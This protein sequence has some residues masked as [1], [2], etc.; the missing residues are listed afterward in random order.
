MH[1]KAQLKQPPVFYLAFTTAMFERFG[2]YVLTYLLVLYTKS[3]YGLSDGQAFILFGVV[4]GL[5]YLTPAIGGYLADNVLG[6]RRCILLGLFLE[7][8]GLIC[9]GLSYKI[10]FWLGLG[11]IIVGE[12]LFKTAP[13]NLMAR[14]YTEQDPRIDTGFT[15]YY[16]GMNLGGILSA[17]SCAFIQQYFGWQAAFAVAG[18]ACYL[19][20]LSYF[21]TRHSARDIDSEPGMKKLSLKTWINVTVGIV[22]AVICCTFLAHHSK[23]SDIFFFF[24]TLLILFYFLYEI[25]NSSPEDK[26]KIIACLLLIFIGMAFQVLFFQA[27]TSIILFINRNV[28][29]QLF[30]LTIPSVSFLALDPLWILILSPIL[31]ML[32]NHLRKHNKGIAVTTKFTIGLLMISLCFFVLKFSTL[33]ANGD[34]QV[35]MWWII[36]AFFLYALGELLVAALGVAMV[37]HI[38]PQHMYG[39]MMGAWFLIAT[40]LGASLSSLLATLSNIPETMHDPHLI[41]NIYSH[42]F[43]IIGSIGLTVTVIAFI[44]GPYIK[45][46]ANLEN[47]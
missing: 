6:I 29:H 36:A 14:S 44:L 43:L 20:L 17:L 24:A 38:A 28:I 32:Y 34:A 5:V 25:L 40:A 27:F 3:I 2:F 47:R 10:A 39:I 9:L 8:S 33:F 22:I 45:R 19:G 41:L 16:M 13:T 37:T 31:A 46:M 21:F 42:T 4:N 18:L 12:G 23:I 15:L 26:L 1:T 11:L 30:G 35:S 7:G